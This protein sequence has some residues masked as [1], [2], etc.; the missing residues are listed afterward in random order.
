MRR[1]TINIPAPCQE[2]WAAMYP[3]GS[4]RHCAS[5][6]E[7][8]VDFT[9]MTDAEIVAFLRQYPAVSCGRFRE[10]QLNRELLVAA[11]P[12]RGW[13][14]W[15]G[16]MATMLGLG[17]LVAPK[18][19]AQVTPARYWGGPAPASAVNQPKQP[20]STAEGPKATGGQQGATTQSMAAPATAAAAA[21]SLIVT[22][23]VHDRLGFR[24]AGARVHIRMN[25]KTID[26]AT[27]DEHGHFRMAVPAGLLDES[28]TIRAMCG[29]RNERATY[30]RYL[31]ADVP[32]ELARHRPYILHLKKRER[33]MGGKFR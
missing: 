20:A 29:P 12:V 24:I 27:S 9:R 26:A 6:Q 2:K 1:T 3:V 17:S 18:A 32:L 4:G 7:V 8:V 25:G 10:S 13:R 5:C 23:T 33:V 15:A 31:R 28:A 14:R 22:G 16:A 19:E 21:D 30:T 11:Q